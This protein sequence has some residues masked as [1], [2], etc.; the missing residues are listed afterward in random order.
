MEP[1]IAQF[2]LKEAQMIGAEIVAWVEQKITN[3][4]KDIPQ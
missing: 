2:L 4:D 3:K 1:E